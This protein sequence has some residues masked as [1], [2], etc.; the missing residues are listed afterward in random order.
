MVGTLEWTLGPL[1]SRAPPPLTC[2]VTLRKDLLPLGPWVSHKIMVT[3]TLI[4]AFIKC[5]VLITAL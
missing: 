5:Y 1:K 2:F 3:A 4:T